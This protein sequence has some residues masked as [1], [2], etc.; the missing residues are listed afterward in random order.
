MKIKTI[1][2]M[3][4]I[5]A[6]LML[7][8][9]AF[10]QP[11]ESLVIGL[12]NASVANLD[13]LGS[14]ALVQGNLQINAQLFDT[15]VKFR[16]GEYVPN[17]VQ[18]WEANED[19]TEWTLS[20]RD[21]VNFTDGS[22]LDAE[23]VVASVNRVTTQA[24]PLAG[25][26]SPLTVTASG[27]LEVTVSSEAGQGALLGK[28]SMLAVIPS[29]RAADENFGLEPVGSGPFKLVS[30]DPSQSVEL[31]AN[32]NY[33]GG[34][35][36]LAGVTFR[37]V[38]EQ[39]ARLTALETGEI[40]L[41]WTLPDDA[42][43]RLEGI[44]DVTV[45]TVSTLANLVVWYN[46][47]RAVF[48]DAAVRQALWKA[49]DFEGIISVLYP[50]T[51]EP[52]SGPLPDAVFGAS[53]Q[54]PYAYDPD[55]ARAELE[56]AGFDF[57]GTIRILMTNNNYGPLVEAMVADWA[58][59]GVNAE[60]DLQEAAVGTQR[61]LA[62]DW[63]MVII[64]PL[65]TSTGDADYNLGRLYTCAANRTGHCNAELDELLAA[66]GSASDQARRA[67][68]YAQAGKIIWDEAMGIYPM[69]VRQIWAWS[70][71][72]EGVKLDSIYKPDLTGIHFAK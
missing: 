45:E 15:L 7:T 13:P 43:S 11:K 42:V 33:W 49:I 46:G 3:G 56:A 41:T 57:D 62:L 5:A 2:G 12:P 19:A 6:A 25:L 69:S 39:A 65:V 64:Q 21:D 36:K 44:S 30:F 8:A 38:P 32:E 68:L 27:P 61:L 72:V 58:R 18:S 28:L 51:G 22:S 10:A 23:D 29:E 31:S 4:G 52:M 54:T 60:L 63:D 9:P 55:A 53:E 24:G 17:L 35:P 14:G 67:D 37:M 59:I 66:A 70:D 26:F 16:D 71:A 47:Q 40:D 50:S 34:A 20:L 1:V 48:E